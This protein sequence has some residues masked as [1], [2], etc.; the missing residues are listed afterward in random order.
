MLLGLL[1]AMIMAGCINTK[2]TS[3]CLNQQ[4]ICV[5]GEARSQLVGV[6][7]D[8]QTVSNGSMVKRPQVGVYK[9]GHQ[10]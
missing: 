1:A 4:R 5:A 9:G 8:W 2:W 6:V 7:L 10:H 3:Y